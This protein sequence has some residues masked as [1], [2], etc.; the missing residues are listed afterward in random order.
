MLTNHLRLDVEQEESLRLT[1]FSNLIAT[2][3]GSHFA[4]LKSILESLT[5]YE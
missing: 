5:R 4:T 2:L 3:P 1:S